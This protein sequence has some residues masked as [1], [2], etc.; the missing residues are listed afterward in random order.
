MVFRTSSCVLEEIH[1]RL[2][3]PGVTNMVHFIRKKHYFT[4]DVTRIVSPW[5]VCAR[6]KLR[7]DREI[8]IKAKPPMERIS[9]DFKGSL[10]SSTLNKYLFIVIDKYSRFPFAFPC[11]YIPTSTVK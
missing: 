11:K 7:K 10:P 4:T 8:L 6:V 1:D 9:I 5:K 2:C 3:P